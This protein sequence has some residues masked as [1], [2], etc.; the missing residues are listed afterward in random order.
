MGI[1]MMIKYDIRKRKS[2]AAVI[3]LLSFLI[4]LL[5]ST[6]VSV[7]WQSQEQYDEAAARMHLPEVIN[8]FNKG[9]HSDADEVT[10]NL[11]KQPET[12][13][14][15][16][17]NILL[18]R[19]N[20]IV[21]FK[22]DSWFSSGTII[23]AFPDQYSLTEGTRKR[24]GI[25]LPITL[26]DSKHLETGDIVTLKLSGQIKK[27]RI[28][29]FFED[30]FLGSTMT[31]FKQLF[32]DRKT[33]EKL[34]KTTEALNYKSTM[35]SLWTNHDT[36]KDFTSRIKELNGKTGF[37]RKGTEYIEQPLMKMSAMALT[38]IFLGLIFLFSLLM[39]TVMLITIRY[40][41][42]SSLEDDYK[43]LGILNA[44]GYS[45]RKL[46]GAKILQTAFLFGAG[47]VAGL[48]GSFFTVPSLGETAMEGS[49][50]LWHGGIRLEPV[51]LS[52]LAA[53]L[54]VVLTAWMSLRCVQKISTVQAIRNGKKDICFT[55][56]YQVSLVKLN[57]PSL[58]LRMAVK[59]VSVR[60]PQY[61]LLVIVCGFMIYSMVSISALHENMTDIKKT[62]VL[63]GSSAS[64][65]S[66]ANT[67]DL[68]AD[69]SIL[70]QDF[71]EDTKKLSEVKSIYSTESQYLDMEHQ[72]M[73]LQVVSQ[74]NNENF[75]DPLK[76]RVPKYDNEMMLTEVS[77]N[78]L[79]KREGDMVTVSHGGRRKRILCRKRLE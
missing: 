26:K 39:L 4:T 70:F 13:E 35:V 66:I 67:S 42:A 56:R 28:A 17:E 74:F 59:H 62:A 18:L 48:F 50:I 73:L 41:I 69:S 55:K 63:F 72:K 78:Y 49:G 16:K 9:Q 44:L 23:R 2:Q 38:D 24:D 37:A 65:I 31:G 58:P 15:M 77:S 30:P 53:A 76:G 40:L 36:G 29:G 47:G 68:S 54:F 22:D 5:I 25:Y 32:L 11:Q 57:F 45:K 51:I 79:G 27:Y 6:S 19:E 52:I 14:V 64:D 12:E 1:L 43:E 33:Y 61:L 75:L 3:F 7:L 10:K 71:I 21:R 60:L 46:L 8:I 20:Q 34:S